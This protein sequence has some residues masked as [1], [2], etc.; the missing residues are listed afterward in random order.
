VRSLVD[1]GPLE[2]RARR[3]ALALRQA[4]RLASWAWSPSEW[5][6]PELGH[7]A[8]FPH[9]VYETSIPIAR[10]DAA[11]HPLL[12]R[13][14]RINVALAAPRFDGVV[15]SP[16]APLS[17]W[18]ALGRVTA[19]RGFA[20]GMELRSGCVVPALG[21]GICLLSNAL[22]EMAAR[23]GWTIL[24]RHGHSLDAGQIVGM[25]ATVLWPHVDLR[26]APASGR[27]RLRVRVVR[28]ALVLEVFADAPLRVRAV[29]LKV[30]E[31]RAQAPFRART[32]VR[33]IDGTSEIIARDRKRVLEASERTRNCITC[34]ETACHARVVVVGGAK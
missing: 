23:L 2:L 17:F 16:H 29:H 21:G 27:A 10:D 18:R 1:V 20:W 26:V 8:S 11:A 32:V 22:F 30:I 13:G 24:E 34:D 12:E 25:D 6:A 15:V 5:R 7:A 19:A 14:K 33:T 3:A 4:R 31:G 9:R 28:D